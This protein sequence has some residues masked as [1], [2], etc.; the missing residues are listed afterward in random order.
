MDGQKI[1]NWLFQSALPHWHEQGVDREY[2]GF[3]ER[4][5]PAGLPD[6][7]DFKRIRVQARQIYVFS[8]AALIDPDLARRA[9]WRAAA[10]HGF[11]F[12]SRKYWQGPARGWARTVTPA[13]ELQ[14]IAADIYDQAFVLFACAWY[15]LAAREG[16]ALESAGQTL[17][18]LDRRL[19]CT[20]YGGYFEGLSRS[21]ELIQGPPRLQNPHMHMLE[22]MLA[23]HQA[24]GDYAYMKRGAELFELFRT[25]FF[26]M[27]THSLGEYFTREWMPLDGPQG[28]IAEPGHHFEWSWIL[29]NYASL[30]GDAQAHEMAQ[31]AFEF[32]REHGLNAQ[33]NL[34]YD[35]IGRNGAIMRASHRLWPQTEALKAFVA[36][37]EHGPAA[38]EC[39]AARLRIAPAVD[40][41]FE[42]YLIPGSGIWHD[43]LDANRQPVSN[44]VPAT[45][46]YHL[47]LA[48]AET[49]RY[50]AANKS[51]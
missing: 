7:V 41:I 9:E 18:F 30:A 15:Y 31:M 10:A 2:G 43:Q 28:Q 48:F 25:R 37:A 12:M 23:L 26:D 36:T 8:H 6:K 39:E 19:A 45:S 34:V 29:R 13:G 27:K 24:T 11:E 5:T 38:G 44:F 33:S 42:H 46:L 50:Y 17:D 20:A 4:L 40:A 35:E 51:I 14:D 47:F 49:L 3:T 1:S 32:A 21:G 16:R 22:A